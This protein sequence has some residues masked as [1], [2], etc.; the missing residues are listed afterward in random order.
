MFTGNT[1]FGDKDAKKDLVKVRYEQK[2]KKTKLKYFAN[3]L[4]SYDEIQRL[5]DTVEPDEDI[6]M[7]SE[8]FDAPNF[9]N[10]I[11]LK[12]KILEINVATWAITNSGIACL[13]ECV[14]DGKSPI[15]NCVLDLTHSYKWVFTSG[16]WEV[17]KDKVNFY[18]AHNHSKFIS[19]KTECGYFTFIGSMNLSNN[20]RWE[21]I[22][23]SRGED[24]FNFC[25]KFIEYFKNDKQSKGQ[26]EI[27]VFDEI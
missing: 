26:K 16:A 25:A 4:A 1:L 8:D 18:F 5:I 9:V 22:Q 7:F 11:N 27:T 24:A 21:N 19:I 13:H 14:Q 17:L 23:F 15:I 6:M 10:Y 12:Y 2:L 3:A 20:P